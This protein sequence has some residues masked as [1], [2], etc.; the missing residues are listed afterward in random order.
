MAARYHLALRPSRILAS[1][2]FELT[3]GD[4]K[5]SMPAKSSDVARISSAVFVQTKGS[6]DSLVT[7][8][9]EP[10][11]NLVLKGYQSSSGTGVDFSRLSKT[12]ALPASSRPALRYR[13][14]SRHSG[15]LGRHRSI[16][17]SGVVLQKQFRR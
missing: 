2:R 16:S 6:S 9:R 1:R 4:P 13:T 8:T 7:R 14:P 10:H 5:S 15:Q 17:E 3:H 12:S 11:S